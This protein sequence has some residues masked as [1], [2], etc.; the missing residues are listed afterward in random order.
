VYDDSLYT[1]QSEIRVEG[2]NGQKQVTEYTIF[3]NGEESST[4]RG[5]EEIL[6]E[7]V[8]QVTAIGTKPGKSTDSKGTY[9]W[10]A[11]GIIT[12]DFGYRNYYIGSSYHKGIDI[13][14]EEGQNILAADGG[15]VVC[16][17]YVSGYGNFIQIQHDNGEMTC[18]GHLSGFAVSVGDR[19]YQGQLIGYMGETGS[20]G[21]VHLH[22]ELRQ[23]GKQ[24]DPMPYLPE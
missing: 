6:V 22:F 10:P 7:P 19:V 1:D 24:V 21:A 12:S 3:L 14:G 23:D 18:Y 16:A 11:R 9:I 5:E 4:E 20:A 2:V 8:G 13:L 17:E 15:E